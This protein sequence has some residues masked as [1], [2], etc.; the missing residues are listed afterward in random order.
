MTEQIQ[1]TDPKRQAIIDAATRLF[2][3][4]NYRSVSMDKIAQ[5]APVSKAT[6]YNHFDSKNDLLVAV[7][8]EI[9]ASIVQAVTQ[10]LSTKDDIKSNLKKIA[11]T[12]VDVIYSTGGLAIHRL[13]VAE[14]HEFPELGQMVYDTG[15]R[16]TQEQFETYLQQ[17][18]DS[19]QFSIPDPN[20]AADSFF[21]LLEG[22]L[23]FRCLLGVQP[24]PNEEEKIQLIE[25]A[26]AFFLRGIGYEEG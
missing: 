26:I 24:P 7:V 5:T 12:L 21:S 14:S 19:G 8:H 18:N 17:L 13:L 4:N 3:E 25:S 6:L 15:V 22:Q 2:L 10:T 1:P 20:F 11:S 9:C 16:P 23:H